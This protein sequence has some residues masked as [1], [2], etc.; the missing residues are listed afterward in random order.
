MTLTPGHVFTPSCHKSRK[1]EKHVVPS[2][3]A[4]SRQPDEAMARSRPQGLFL[5]LLSLGESPARTKRGSVGKATCGSWL[6]A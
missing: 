5:S 1:R 6:V 2:G 3:E 4:A